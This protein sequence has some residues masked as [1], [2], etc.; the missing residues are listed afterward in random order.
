MRSLFYTAVIRSTNVVILREA[1]DL[2]T[3]LAALVADMDNL[4]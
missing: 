2:C 1:K 3:L 4:S